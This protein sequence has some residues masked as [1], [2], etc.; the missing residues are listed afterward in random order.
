[1]VDFYKEYTHYIGIIV[2][3]VV[4]VICDY[5]FSKKPKTWKEE[6][7][8]FAIIICVSFFFGILGDSIEFIIGLFS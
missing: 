3:A 5:L 2:L 8:N 4:V 1:M 7:R 6:R